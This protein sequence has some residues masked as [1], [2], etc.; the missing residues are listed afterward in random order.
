MSSKRRRANRDG[1]FSGST[2]QRAIIDIGSNTVRMVVYGGSMRA[3]TVLLN[4]KVTAKLGR[5]IAEKGELAEEAIELAMRGLKR[6]ALLL[7][8]LGIEKVDT[9]ATA[10]VR[11]ASNADAFVESLCGLGLDPQVISGE[12]EA[13]LGASGGCRCFSRCDRSCRRPWRW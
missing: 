11:D 4:E 5:D 9:V 13:R 8:D 2:P 10:A 3:P 7:D 1:T 6:F 12:E